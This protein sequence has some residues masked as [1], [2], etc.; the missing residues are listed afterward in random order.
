MNIIPKTLS[1]MGLL[2]IIITCVLICTQ[3][4]SIPTNLERNGTPIQQLAAYSI[5]SKL[6]SEA[7]VHEVIQIES[8]T[9]CKEIGDSN[10]YPFVFDDQQ[11]AEKQTWARYCFK[12]FQIQR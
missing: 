5:R 7:L 10:T 9:R 3:C 8:Y 6:N 1:I 11:F 12:K 4:I 2:I